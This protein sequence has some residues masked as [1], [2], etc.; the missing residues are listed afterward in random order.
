M[1]NMGSG[2]PSHW[3]PKKLADAL[4][5][6]RD[7]TSR[8]YLPKNGWFPPKKWW[9]IESK[10]SQTPM[11]LPGRGYQVDPRPWHP[12]APILPEYIISIPWRMAICYLPSGK[13]TV[14]YWK[15]PLKSLIFPLKIVIF[16]SYV[17]LPEGIYANLYIPNN[18]S[19]TVVWPHVNH[20]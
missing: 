3:N 9:F 6:M 18:D 19:I 4:R 5:S 16:H 2:H 17:S 12:R 20:Y 7:G 11:T 14:C 10:L 13:L 8:R 1:V 15:W